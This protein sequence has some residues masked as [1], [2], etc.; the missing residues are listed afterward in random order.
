MPKFYGQNKRRRNPRYFLYEAHDD[1]LNRN[2]AMKIKDMMPPDEAIDMS[3]DSFY[4]LVVS[5]YDQ[6][7][8]ETRE[9]WA[10]RDDDLEEIRSHLDIDMGEPFSWETY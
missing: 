5:V 9:G 3:D 6:Y 2:V 1:D 4:D 8:D 10:P 7:F